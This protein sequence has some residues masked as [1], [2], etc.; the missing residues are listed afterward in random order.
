MDLL[1]YIL[2]SEV[3]GTGS[4]DVWGWVDPITGVEYA[5]LGRKSGT[6]FIDVQT[7]LIL[8]SLEISR[9]Q[10]QAQLGRYHGKQ[11]AFIVS[12]AHGHG[13]QVFDL[14]KLGEVETLLLSL[15]RLQYEG[16]SKAHNLV[17]NE[18]TDMLY[19]VGTNTFEGGLHIL[20]VNNPINLF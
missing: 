9:R 16:F 3:G 10:E 1:S 2:D 12:E 6:A 20:D 5:I 14:M 19:A 18:E 7:P 17:M 13:M 11:F 15:T 8:Y 4:N